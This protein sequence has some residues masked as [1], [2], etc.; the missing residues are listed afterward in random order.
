M[1]NN[2]IRKPFGVSVRVWRSRLGISQEELAERAELHRTY[3]SDVERGARNVSLASIEKLARALQVSIPTLLAHS[4]GNGDANQV[5]SADKLVDILFVE[6]LEDD[7]VLT[8]QALQEAGISNRLFIVRDGATA[9]DFLFG[10]G[11]YAHRPRV[12][13][14]LILLDLK[15]PKVSG[16]EVLRQAKADP[17]TSDIPIVIMTISPREAAGNGCEQLGA[18]GYIVKPVDFHNLS[19]I[20]PQLKMQWALLKST[21]V[22][23]Q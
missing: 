14:H 9:L 23:G 10:T 13:P 15:L 3:I 16:L 6:D 2:D 22:P 4:E 19:A 5:L 12:R 7:I 1:N 20:T 18:S 17:R 21:G 11:D 8:K